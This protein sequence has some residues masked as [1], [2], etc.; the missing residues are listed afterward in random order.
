ML[1]YSVH[2][3]RPSASAQFFILPVFIF[4]VKYTDII[5]TNSY[6]SLEYSLF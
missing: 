5:P 3:P 4:A 2:L 6:L 1:Q